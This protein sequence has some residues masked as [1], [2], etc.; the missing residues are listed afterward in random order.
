MIERYAELTQ[1]LLDVRVKLDAQLRE[2]ARAQ[3]S[4]AER[5]ERTAAAARARLASDMRRFEELL[6]RARAAGLAT[7]DAQT[8]PTD[9][10]GEPGKLFAQMIERLAE[11][12]SN[13]EHTQKA[14]AAGRQRQEKRSSELEQE[15]Q[16]RLAEE[17]RRMHEARR[18]D[19]VLAALAV[20]CAAACATTGIASSALA[21]LL[22]PAAATIVLSATAVAL[23]STTVPRLGRPWSRTG[24]AY[25]TGAA[26]WVGSAIAAAL[27]GLYA[28]ASLASGFSQP[29]FG[30]AAAVALACGTAQIFGLR[31]AR[32][33]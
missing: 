31:Q 22:A 33:G 18:H 2:H 10:G 32:R 11:A 30:I 15:H 13:A 29:R 3:Q 16:R 7:D 21:G 25:G 27:F 5:A 20:A 1:T 14:L 12:I 28:V 6:A 19:R 8:P 24:V 9:F 17:Q 4:E 23:A 26:P